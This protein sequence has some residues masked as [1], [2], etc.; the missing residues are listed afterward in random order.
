MLEDGYSSTYSAI[1]E[2][3]PYDCITSKLEC[4]GHV[5]KR[6]GSRLER[7]KSSTKGRKLS[8]GK[9]LSGNGRLTAGK[10]D[11]LQNYYGLAIRGTLIM[12]N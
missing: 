7:L 3:K 6:V 11:V 1:I 8:D 12:L 9:G 5:Q 10:M 2:S 4:I